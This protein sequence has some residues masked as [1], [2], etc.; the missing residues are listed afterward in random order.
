M[1]SKKTVSRRTM[2]KGAAVGGG[3]LMLSRTG[4]VSAAGTAG[5]SSTVDSYVLPSAPGVQCTALITTGD[6]AV[7]G[8][9]MVG[10]PDGLGALRNGDSFSVF[11]HHELGKAVGISRA[12][13]SIGA[14]VSKWTIDRT[15]L[16]VQHGE[17]LVASATNLMQWD[18]A[19]SS[20]FAGTTAWD[21]FCSADLPVEKALRYHDVGT[22]ERLF[23]GGEEVTFGRAWARIVTGP[24]QGQAWELPRL[25]KMAF[26]NV[27]ACPHSKE[28]TIVALFDDGS[29]DI[30]APAASNPSEVYIYVGTKQADGNEI[31]RAGL[32][33]GKLYG[34][35]V[36][37]GHGSNATLVAGET[38][39]FGL[40]DAT[41]GFVGKGFFELVELGKEG[42]VSGMSGLEIEQD[43]MSK[44]VFRMMRPEDGAW[45]PHHGGGLYFVTTASISLH[46]RLWNLQFQ[47]INHPELGGKIEVVLTNTDLPST[48][49]WRMFDNITIDGVGR[50]FL[51]EDTGNN[52]WVSRIWMLNLKTRVLTE[53]ARHNPELFEPGVNPSLFITQDEESS[54]IIDAAH[55]LGPGW[56]LLAV[57]NHK[58]SADPELVEGGQL[59]AM[60]V[61]ID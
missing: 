54:G 2:L 55:V 50:L 47:D 1:I 16:E 39:D 11:M 60:Y 43:A 51:Q 41:K 13:G 53:V 20:Y 48:D 34:V 52:P 58:A 40:G 56:F 46:S 61:P 49:G 37:R 28:K 31:E 57:Q 42:D 33:N 26:E 44:N 30:N 10:I 6:A 3:A 9:R 18:P 29:I 24:N 7:N 19:S 38:S 59:V 22:S 36:I 35:R 12:H 14:F 21:R 23:L 4:L 45:E 17:D 27:V 32:T 15:T 25:G 8:Y 5:P